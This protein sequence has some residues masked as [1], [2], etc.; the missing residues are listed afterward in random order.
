MGG[1]ALHD[2]RQSRY[3]RSE[4]ARF[5]TFTSNSTISS[6]LDERCKKTYGGCYRRIYRRLSRFSH[7]SCLGRHTDL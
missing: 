3:L 1:P 2:Y 4:P 5:Y 6:L 7:H